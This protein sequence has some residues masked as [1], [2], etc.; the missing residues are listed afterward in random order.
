MVPLRRFYRG[1]LPLFVALT[2]VL[3][4]S[5]VRADP[6]VAEIEK[7]IG[8][9]WEKLEPIVEQYNKVHSQLTKNQKKA[10][11]LE[12]KIM[13]LQL[14][15]SVALSQVGDLASDYYIRGGATSSLNALL[16][17]PTPQD[18]I[19]KIMMLD[20]LARMQSDKVAVAAKAKAGFDGQKAAL[21]KLI[22]E[23]K[24]QD[25]DLAARKAVIQKE[26]DRLQKL[27][28]Q[29]YGNTSTGGSLRI[30]ACPA[31]FSGGTATADRGY[32]AAK[33]AC[34]LI[35]K[36]YV[37]GATGPNSYDCSGLTQEAWQAAG[38]NLTHYTGDQWGE[39]TSVSTPIPGDLVFFY[40]DRHHV[41]IFV[42]TDASGRRLMVHAPH[43][44][45]HVR[46]AY[47][48][49]MPLSPGGAYRRP[50]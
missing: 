5:A 1:L 48:G 36:P 44:G 12:A 6:S 17:A 21:D 9:A 23:Q 20:Q 28:Q 26:M 14:S 31:S 29:A 2:V 40:G 4:P 33:R 7:Q 34:A 32:K 39:S 10:R 22:A 8:D 42:G 11:D 37:W 45:D 50:K 43:S 19:N 27:R 25:T 13:P 3:V 41:G 30:G 18:F 47:I 16:N 46:M 15:V 49:N 35:G 24:A 38:E